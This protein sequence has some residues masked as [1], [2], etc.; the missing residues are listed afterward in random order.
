VQASEDVRKKNAKELDQI[1]GL[2]LDSVA[3]E[4]AIEKE[5]HRKPSF[6]RQP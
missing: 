4:K 1:I 3:N 6:V 5:L 2:I